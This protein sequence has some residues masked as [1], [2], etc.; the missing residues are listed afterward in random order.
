MSRAESQNSCSEHRFSRHVSGAT[1]CGARA[2][3][4]LKGCPTPNHHILI[5]RA[6]GVHIPMPRRLGRT[7]KNIFVLCRNIFGPLARDTRRMHLRRLSVR[8]TCFFLNASS[9]IAKVMGRT[10]IYATC[11][12]RNPIGG[13]RR[14]NSEGMPHAKPPYSYLSC[15]G[16][17]YSSARRAG[18]HM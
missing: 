17:A 12:G 5:C 7:C 8:C 9:G 11:L 18:S 14:G 15:T 3:D 10:L 2:E 6:H 13:T 4:H 16:G 1:S